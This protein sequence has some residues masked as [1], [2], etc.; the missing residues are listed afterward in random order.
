MKQNPVEHAVETLCL[1]G[2]KALWTDISLMEDGEVLPE[3][4][5][6]DEVQRSQVL[7]EIKSIM[8]VYKGSCSL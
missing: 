8:A 1:K 7:M 3:L 5:G 4:R 2:C 6:L